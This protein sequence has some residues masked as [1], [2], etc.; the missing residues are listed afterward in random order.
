MNAHP[1]FPSRH[2]TLASVHLMDMETV[3]AL[4]ANYT[5]AWNAKSAAVVASFF[6]ENGSI[7]INLG[8]PWEGRAGVQDMAAGFY[9]D[10]PDLNLTC[11]DVRFSGNH[12][13]FVWT[14]TGHDATTNQP[15]NIRGWEELDLDSDMKV[16]ASRG[17][18]DAVDYAKQAQG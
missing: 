14:F 7:V 8:E 18:F 3:R 12:V 11:D 4:A 10:V 6:A 16:S 15:L 9:A 13:V 1:T 2:H 5:A 17:W